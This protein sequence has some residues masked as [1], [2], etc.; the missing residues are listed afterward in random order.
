MGSVK[1]LSRLWKYLFLMS[2]G[3]I[4]Q[5]YIDW[6]RWRKSFFLM[7]WKSLLR[8]NWVA[9]LFANMYRNCSWVFIKSIRKSNLNR[10][11]LSFWT[12]RLNFVMESANFASNMVGIEMSHIRFWMRVSDLVFLSL[13]L[14]S[15]FFSNLM[16]LLNSLGSTSK[17]CLFYFVYPENSIV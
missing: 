13:T 17:A 11:S 14:I 4:R 10:V 3:L 15:G 1:S 16:S 9:S 8:K 2:C 12:S 7:I 6:Q 5:N